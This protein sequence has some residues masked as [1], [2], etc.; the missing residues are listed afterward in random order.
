MIN[1]IID[2]ATAERDGLVLDVATLG[3]TVGRLKHE[4]AGIL[5]D[6]DLSGGSVEVM[7]INE[8]LHNARR[9]LSAWNK[10]RECLDFLL[11]YVASITKEGG[12]V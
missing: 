12:S 10:R 6:N 2:Q 7:A 5:F 9:V 8:K 3:A 4:R 11:D 1:K